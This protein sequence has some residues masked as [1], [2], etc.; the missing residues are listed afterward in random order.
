[1][2]R[3]LNLFIRSFRGELSSEEKSLLDKLLED[4][5]TAAE[6]EMYRNIWDQAIEKGKSSRPD[7]GKSWRLL[8]SRM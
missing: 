8:H 6:Y 4:K 2:G 1:M 7:S 3:K 5:G